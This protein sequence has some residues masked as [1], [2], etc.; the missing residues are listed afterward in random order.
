MTA[1]R[2]DMLLELN[3]WRHTFGPPR[4]KNRDMHELIGE[5]IAVV[6]AAPAGPCAAVPAGLWD[7]VTAAHETFIALGDTGAATGEL[8]DAATELSSA[9]VD[10]QVATSRI[11][12]GD[13]A[14]QRALDDLRS[15]CE[16]VGLPLTASGLV[17]HWRNNTAATY[18]L[19]IHTACFL[20][21]ELLEGRDD[22]LAERGRTFLEHLKAPKGDG[23]PCADDPLIAEQL[24]SS[25]DWE[26]LPVPTNFEIAEHLRAGGKIVMATSD[27]WIPDPGHN[28]W[29]EGWTGTTDNPRPVSPVPHYRLVPLERSAD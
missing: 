3:N 14:D 27:G 5:I 12:A 23:N 20:I 15:E 29:P 25:L 24:A 4:W 28:S 13:R 10:A 7:K 18:A 26:R 22:E 11:E 8:V 21:G 16:A 19:D 6:E 1:T 2:D 17:R 9:L